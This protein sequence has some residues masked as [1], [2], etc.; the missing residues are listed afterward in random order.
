MVILI[1]TVVN[2]QK[3]FNNMTT[4][5]NRLFQEKYKLKFIKYQK[6]I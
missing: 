2:I 3:L 6:Y 4:Y 1:N 5:F